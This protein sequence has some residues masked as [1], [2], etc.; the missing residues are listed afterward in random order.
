MNPT[1]KIFIDRLL[2]GATESI[3]ESLEPDFID[4]SESELEFP[5]RVEV[6]GKAYLAEEHL[7]IQLKIETEAILPCSICNTRIKIP[8]KIGSFYHTEEISGIKGKV[9]DY[10]P[11]LREG[12]LLELPT[13][14]ECRGKCPER[15]KIEKYLSEGDKQFPFADL[16]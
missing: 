14:V 7:I 2:G 3:K 13:Y 9:Y 15:A 4:L 10:T 8:L 16:N 5:S 12:I 11:P 1:L 6:E